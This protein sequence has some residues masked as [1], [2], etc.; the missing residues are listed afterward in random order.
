MDDFAA[1][2]GLAA[3]WLGQVGRATDPLTW[4]R[5]KRA[6][7]R[8]SRGTLVMARDDRAILMVITEQGVGAEELRLPM[9]SVLARMQRH[10][11]GGTR[12]QSGSNPG[13]AS[14]ATEPPPALPRRAEPD[15]HA[16]PDSTG[17][18]TQNRFHEVNG[19]N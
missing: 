3:G 16:A 14:R 15:P 18:E 13:N 17:N 8:G 6:V 19:D 4:N 10:L 11:R 7:L 1:S 2:A 12:Q 5:P 9:E